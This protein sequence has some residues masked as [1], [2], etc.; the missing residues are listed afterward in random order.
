[1][2]VLCFD[3]HEPQDSMTSSQ[4]SV[5]NKLC[6]FFVFTVTTYTLLHT[7]NLSIFSVIATQWTILASFFSFFKGKSCQ[8]TTFHYKKKP[9]DQ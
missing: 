8:Q 4:T 5:N 1:M 3:K 6:Y 2:V 7:S 9:N